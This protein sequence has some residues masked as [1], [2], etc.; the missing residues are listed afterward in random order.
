MNSPSTI[1][2]KKMLVP[3]LVTLLDYV[4]FIQVFFL[5]DSLYKLSHLEAQK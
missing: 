3:I 4:N 5:H 1:W 2:Q